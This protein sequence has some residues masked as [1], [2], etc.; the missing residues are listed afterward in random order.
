MLFCLSC[1]PRV[2]NSSA[3]CVDVLAT[4][5][6]VKLCAGPIFEQMLV[7]ALAHPHRDLKSRCPRL[8]VCGRASVGVG[9]SVAGPEC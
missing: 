8:R 1:A 5:L 9:T 6:Q 4:A 7:C 3:C 2:S